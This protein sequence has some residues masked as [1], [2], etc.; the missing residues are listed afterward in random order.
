MAHF[1]ELDSNNI[2]KRVIVV[3]NKNTSDSNGVEDESIGISYLKA[4]FGED[5]IW[6][7]TS[8]NGNIRKYYAGTGMTYREDLDCFVPAQPYPSWTLNEV[9]IIWEAPVPCPD[10]TQEEIDAGYR[11]YWDE[12]IYNEN[13]NTGWVLEEP[14]T[15]QSSEVI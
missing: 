4:I 3:S 14:P 7:Q 15:E 13:G 2:V 10:L 12:E 9:D 11:Y 5:S 6:K 1:A 8:Y